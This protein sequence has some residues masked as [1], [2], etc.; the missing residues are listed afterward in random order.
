MS[1]RPKHGL[2]TT[3]GYVV[4]RTFN[5]WKAVD[6]LVNGAISRVAV[7]RSDFRRLVA[8]GGAQALIDSL[9]QKTN[10]LS[11]GASLP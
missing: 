1:E 11:G 10:D 2:P 4:R 8:R 3:L 6:I 9:N 7:Q 5:E